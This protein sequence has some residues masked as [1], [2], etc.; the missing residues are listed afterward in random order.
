MS[1][2]LNICNNNICNN[3]ICNNNITNIYKYI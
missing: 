1:N 2:I 3:N